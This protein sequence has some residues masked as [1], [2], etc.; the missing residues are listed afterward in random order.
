M[1]YYIKNHYCF[2]DSLV[3]YGDGVF[4]TMLAVG[5]GIHHWPYHW[6][7]LK[8][9]CERLEITVPDEAALIQQLHTALAIQNNQFSLVKMIVARGQGLRGYRSLPEQPCTVQFNVAPYTFAASMYQGLRVRICQ[10]RLRREA[11]DTQFDEGLLLDYD[12]HLIEG[13]ISNVF[14]INNQQITTPALKTAGVAGTMRAY[15][16]DSLP[17]QGY[18]VNIQALTLTDIASA[19][20]V[21]LTNASGGVMPVKS[22]QGIAKSFELAPAQTIRHLTEHPCSCV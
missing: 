1:N 11:A 3:Q 15:L 21:F 20:A 14:L 8:N 4:E 17:N 19:D 7:R 18:T 13:L 5:S 2:D 16:L 22:I 12:S 9:S 10:T 6:T